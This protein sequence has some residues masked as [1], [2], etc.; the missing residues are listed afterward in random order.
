[1]TTAARA[2]SAATVLLTTYNHEAFVGQAVESVLGQITDFPVDLVVL[3]DC[4]TDQTAAIVRAYQRA[5]PDRVDLRVSD[6]NR[7]DNARFMDAVRRC[8]TPYIALIDG[9]DYWTSPHKLQRQVD[10]LEAQPNCSICFH[11]VRI[12]TEDRD[13]PADARQHAAERPACTIDH[14]IESCFITYSSAVVRAAAV[15]PFPEWYV[16]EDCPDWLLFLMAARRGHIHRLDETMAV[17]RQHPGGFWSGRSPAEQIRR[18][19]GFYERLSRWLPAEFHDRLRTLQARQ[20]YELAAAHERQ[21]AESDAR[22]ALAACLRIEPD[23]RRVQW[24]L[25]I[26]GGNAARLIYPSDPPDAVR[27]V[28][29][30]SRS[31][32]LY[33]VQLN[34]LHVPATARTEY[35]L[36]FRARSDRPR[37][38]HVGFAGSAPTWAN[39]GLYHAIQVTPDWQRFDL[40]FRPMKD[41]P[42]GRIHFDLGGDDA[43]VE[44]AAVS[45]DAALGSDGA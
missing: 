39:L 40:T 3:D 14:L 6:V 37:Q 36:R 28:I 17:Y 15:G 30:A 20:W 8:R 38:A 33:D 13:T 1:M 34:Q 32:A 23:F 21:G 27:V 12:L 45:L 35:V 11:N 24:S 42:D 22:E 19:I 25:R 9:D 44:I 4:S 10:C 5:H 26:A 7:C 29:E 41:E 18:V 43:A 31:R 2:S 16:T